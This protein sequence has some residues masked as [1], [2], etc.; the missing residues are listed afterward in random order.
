MEKLNRG[1]NT[2]DSVDSIIIG[3]GDSYEARLAVFAYYGEDRAAKDIERE[4]YMCA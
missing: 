2:H 3:W 4:S 1:A